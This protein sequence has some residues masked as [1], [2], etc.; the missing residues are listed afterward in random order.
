MDYHSFFLSPIYYSDASYNPHSLCLVV[1]YIP[2]GFKPTVFPHGNAKSSKPFFPTLPSTVERIRSECTVS[3]PKEVMASV[4]SQGGGIVGATYPGALPRDEQQIS[5]MKK[6]LPRRFISG[7]SQVCTKG[8][9]LYAIMVQAH[10]DDAQKFI[11]NIKMFPEPA[12]L[13]ANDRQLTDLS[14]FCCD[15]FESCVLTVDPTFCLG[16]FD[17]TP[18][19][20]R[21]LLLQSVRTGKPPVMIGPT[22]V[23]Y[24]KS[25]QTYLFFA[26]SLIGLKKELAKI[27]AFGTDGERALIDAFM[28][29]FRLAVHLTCFIHVQKNIKEKLSVCCISE[30]VKSE[31]VGD[32]FGKKVGTTLLEGLV[33][34]EDD[35][36]EATLES[37]LEKW[38]EHQSE[39]ASVEEFCEWFL[40]NK[41]EVIRKSMLRSVRQEAGL[42]SPPD[43]FFTNASECVNSIIK[44]KVEYKSS[45]LPQFVTKLRELCDE[46]EREVERAL[47]CRGKYRLRPQYRQLE[48]DESKWFSMTKDQRVKHLKK[49]GETAEHLCPMS[50]SLEQ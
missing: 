2:L 45:E 11:Q 15:P 14:R 26:S 25:F 8:D 4:S 33:D 35:L 39:A 21:H 41:K 6:R 28:H 23:H 27:R 50:I 16:E 18:V 38:K 47:I 22:L 44:A 17:V 36:F 31:I 19:T 49:V 10:S 24:K 37:L 5:Q 1:Y 48:V 42:G 43:S 30:E 20:Y 46:Q 40:K 32:I 7:S 9:E 34:S 29:E 3:G 13:V 12:V